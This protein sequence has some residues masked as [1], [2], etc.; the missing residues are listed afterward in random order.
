MFSSQK[1][2]IHKLILII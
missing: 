2:E 1:S